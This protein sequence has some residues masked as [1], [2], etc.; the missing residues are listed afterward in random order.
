M[1]A[2]IEIYRTRLIVFT[3]SFSIFLFFFSP[4]FQVPSD[5]VNWNDTRSGRS[6]IWNI[7][8]VSVCSIYN[9]IRRVDRVRSS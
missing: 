3:S 6:G 5:V 8:F 7:V 1:A 4:F 2:I 9:A